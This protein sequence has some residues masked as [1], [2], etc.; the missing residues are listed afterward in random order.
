MKGSAP[1]F[2]CFL[3]STYE[4]LCLTSGLDVNRDIEDVLAKR[5]Y[6]DDDIS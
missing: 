6:D 2:F 3:V 5:Q 1:V 4:L